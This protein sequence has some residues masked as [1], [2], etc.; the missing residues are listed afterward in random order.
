SD[1]LVE[2]R[3]E[4]IDEGLARLGS[5]AQAAAA[6]EDAS[7]ADRVYRRL[8][9]ETSVEDDIAL[10]AVESL[11]LGPSLQLTLDAQPGVLAGLRSTLGRW[12]ASEGVAENELFDITLATSEAAA[13]AVEHAYR[14]EQATFLV[15]CEHEAHSVRVA[16]RDRGRWR[17]ARSYG[18]GRGLSIMRALM[19]TVE[20]ERGEDGTTVVLTKRLATG[21][22]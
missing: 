5:A 12:L 21:A 3:G 20:I 4:A 22:A 7:F 15:S 9:D 6:A 17:D 2:R 14:A 18:R 13:N 16:V 10:L 8:V 1:G 11:P 19:D